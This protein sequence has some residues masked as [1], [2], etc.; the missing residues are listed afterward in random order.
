MSRHGISLLPLFQRLDSQNEETCL[1]CE[2]EINS[3][4]T[5]APAARVHSDKNCCSRPSSC[6]STM[7][8]GFQ[9]PSYTRG[10][11]AADK[12]AIITNLERNPTMHPTTSQERIDIFST[13]YLHNHCSYSPGFMRKVAY[14]VQYVRYSREGQD[15]PR[16]CL[17]PQSGS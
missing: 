9:T 10:I 17:N 16:K 8:R 12:A 11:C 1:K 4:L 3:E 7:Q 5:Q 13:Q 15:I 6:S 14:R 2:R